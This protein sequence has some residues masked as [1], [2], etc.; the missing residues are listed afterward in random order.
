MKYTAVEEGAEENISTQV[1]AL[2][3][4]KLRNEHHN[5]HQL[6]L[7]LPLSL[8]KHHTMKTYWGV[9]V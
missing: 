3:W 1:T 5:L 2:G 7:Q 6:L 9:E 8:S 4:R